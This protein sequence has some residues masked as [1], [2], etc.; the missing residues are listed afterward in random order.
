M[1][2]FELAKKLKEASYSHNGIQ[3][4]L[5]DHQ[6]PISTE[7]GICEYLPCPT[8]SELIEACGDDFEALTMERSHV[9]NG[10]NAIAFHSSRHGHGSTPDEAVASLWLSLHPTEITKN[11]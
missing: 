11:I 3:K 6:H 9:G 2:T 5:K 4:C 1:I 7:S 8:L 10:W